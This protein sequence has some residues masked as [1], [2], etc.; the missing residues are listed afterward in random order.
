MAETPRF[1]VKSLG[2]N[3]KMS[4]RGFLT[5]TAGVAAAGALSACTEPAHDADAVGVDQ[6]VAQEIEP[7]DGIH[8]S[9]IATPAQ[10]HLI[11]LGLN[12]RAGVDS[13]AVRRLLTLL[14][15]D[16]RELTQARNPVGS[17]E[18][19][20][21]SSPSRLTITA[22]AGA[23]LFD[24]LGKS[25]MKPAWL[26]DI[27]VFSKDR[28]DPRWGQ[29]DLVLQI[30]SDDPM[31]AAFAMRHMTR[32]GSDYAEVKWVQQGFLNA[33]GTLQKGETP[34]NLFGQKDGTINPHTAEEFDKQVWID[35]EDDSPRWM[36]GGTCMVVRR[37]S[38][39]LDTWER[40]DRQSR[41]VAI[42][43]DIVEG[44]PLSGGKE[45]DS[46]DYEAVD[47]YGIPKID[48][49]SHMAL[50]TPPSDLPNQ[51]LLRRAYTYNETP[52]VGTDQL[53]NAGLVF[54]CF[55]KDPRKQFIPIQQR[56]DASDR[57]NE[58]IKHIGSAV[59]AIFPGTDQK[60][61]EASIWGAALFDS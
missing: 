28:L 47:E 34:R 57:L 46:A 24:I 17:L 43:R 27:P 1:S 36:H 61:T 13:A 3:L 14:T 52:M 2:E 49:R 19:E 10:S 25:E 56:L 39:N 11:V 4:R 18:P 6:T 22:G 42:G 37:I 23:R 59:Y 45:H 48:A 53:S 41:E 35:N 8:Q 38:M 9:G 29:T 60:K 44:A 7:F 54:C 33:R 15:E 55:Q 40:L 30:C 12:C 20:M 31:T 32:S 51:R 58:W 26:K 5:G 50:A 21:T 16:A